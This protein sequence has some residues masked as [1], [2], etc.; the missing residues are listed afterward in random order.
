MSSGQCLVPGEED[1]YRLQTFDIKVEQ[2]Q[3]YLN[4]P[5]IDALSEALGTRKTIIH[6]GMVKPTIVSQLEAP[7]C[8]TGGGCGDKSLEW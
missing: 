8:S 7:V 2:G 1:K 5:P 6:R 4:L 3:V